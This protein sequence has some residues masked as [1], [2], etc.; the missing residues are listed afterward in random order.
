MF[1]KEATFK[2]SLTFLIKHYVNSS[3]G[4]SGTY[5]YKNN[6]FLLVVSVSR[7]SVFGMYDTDQSELADTSLR[8]RSSTHTV[9]SELAHPGLNMVKPE[10]CVQNR[11][12]HLPETTILQWSSPHRFEQNVGHD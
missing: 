4:S 8:L 6:S 9:P 2:A 1:A 7:T 5:S 3:W 12:R 11:L 10:S